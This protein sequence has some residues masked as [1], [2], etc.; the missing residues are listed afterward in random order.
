MTKNK[1]GTNRII[2]KNDIYFCPTSV[3]FWKKIADVNFKV[4]TRSQEQKQDLVKR[5][6][7]N[8]YCRRRGRKDI[9]RWLEA[10]D[11]EVYYMKESD[12]FFVLRS[13]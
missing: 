4:R 7:F 11:S 10:D 9:K 2:E 8:R 12:R 6:D 3:P 1:D 5:Q 13:P